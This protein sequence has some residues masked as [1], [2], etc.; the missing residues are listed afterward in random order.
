M[1]STRSKDYYEVGSSNQF[2]VRVL[3]MWLSIPDV[4]GWDESSFRILK[5]DGNVPEDQPTLENLA[6]IFSSLSLYRK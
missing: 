3:T 4:Y 2:K 6:S 1:M 5:D